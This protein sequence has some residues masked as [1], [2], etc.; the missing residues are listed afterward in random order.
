LV[1]ETNEFSKPLK[2]DNTTNKAILLTIIPIAEIRVIIFMAFV[3]L[4][5][6]AYRLAM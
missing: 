5:L 2:T 6:K 3:L 1:K 4:L